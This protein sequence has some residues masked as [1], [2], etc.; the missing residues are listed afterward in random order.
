MSNITKQ[1]GHCYKSTFWAC[2]AEIGW[3]VRDVNVVKARLLRAWTPEFGTEFRAVF[4]ALTSAVHVVIEREE[5]NLDQKTR[6]RYYLSD[7]G[8]SDFSAHVVGMGQAVFEAEIFDSSK[9][10]KRAVAGDYEESFSY[11][12]PYEPS[13]TLSFEA[14]CEK[15]EV[16]GS[17]ARERW[18]HASKGDW[19]NIESE[20]HAKQAAKILPGV[21]A[22]LA[23]IPV[24]LDETGD[25]AT[26]VSL[27]SEL[28]HYLNLLINEK[29]QE[30]LAI[31]EQALRAWWGLKFLADDVGAF[32]TAH[33]DLLP[34]CES[35]YWG[36]N[37]I[38]EH[39]QFMGGL[40]SFKFKFHYDEIRS[41]AS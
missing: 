36:E 38:N 32:R 18:D 3:P 27:A 7:D 6:D 29:T 26:G 28:V 10:F 15:R 34:M 12:I 41:K 35:Q 8:L 21:A 4:E 2:V 24:P 25:E 9:L 22:F 40:P 16:F 14:W 13:T 17:R 33:R 20:F 11:V 31:S 37:T 19:E 5:K 23:E 30:A 39:R 1:E